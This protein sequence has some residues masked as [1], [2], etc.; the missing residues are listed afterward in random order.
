MLGMEDA[1]LRAKMTEFMSRQEKEV[2]Q[3]AEK[4]EEVGWRSYGL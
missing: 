3:K 4:L 2:L 1:R